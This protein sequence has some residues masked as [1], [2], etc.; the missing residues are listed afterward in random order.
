MAV[1]D[2]VDLVGALRRL[3][4]ALREAGDHTLGGSECLEEARD[5]RLAQARAARRRGQVRRCF[6]GAGERGL[7]PGRPSPDVLFVQRAVF[8]EMD[9]KAAEQKRVRA[10]RDREEQ[11]RLFAGRR[12]PRIDHHDAGTSA[13]A[14][15]EHA[16]KQ[17]GMAPGSV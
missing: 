15:I 2:G 16:A 1:D 5:L 3:V 7:E 17:D 4:H 13:R 6:K 12:A 11:V 10:R 14:V 9:E 8:R